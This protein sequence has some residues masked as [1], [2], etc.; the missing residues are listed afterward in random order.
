M[1]RSIR[2]LVTLILIM[3]LV[4]SVV[5]CSKPAKKKE[6][7]KQE[8][9]QEKKEEPKKESKAKEEVKEIEITSQGKTTKVKINPKRVV[10]IELSAIDTIDALGKGDVIVGMPKATAVNYL[11]KFFD[12]TKVEN[13]GSLKESDM[14]KI[15][16]LKPDLIILGRRQIKQFD[17]YA[18]IAPTVIIAIDQKKPYMESLK[19]NV[20]MLGKIF[21]SEAKAKELLEGFDKRVKALNEKSKGKTALVTIATKNNLNVLGPKSRGSII[22]NEIGFNNLGKVDSTHGDNVSFEFIVKKNPEY[23]FVLDR[24]T[25][26]NAKGSKTAQEVVE[27]ELIKGTNAYK[28]KKIVYLTPD[29]WYLAEGG[30]S[31]TDIMLKDLEKGIK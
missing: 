26:I 15:N 19:E 24:D 27:N 31:S 30:V 5:A 17:E 20:Q 4:I 16:S 23:L 10:S 9:K 2:V 22:S 14:E 28:N 18:K 29:V 11:K 25:A 21:N 3:T 8:N 7:P 12:N 13:V 1:K 6:E